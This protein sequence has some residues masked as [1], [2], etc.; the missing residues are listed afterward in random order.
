MSY[1]DSP[2]SL[3]SIADR[4]PR[5]SLCRYCFGNSSIIRTSLSLPYGIEFDTIR[6]YAENMDAAEILTAARRQAGLSL[7][8]LARRSGTSHSAL[9]AYESR[10]TVPGFD[11]LRRV[12]AAAGYGLDWQ[13]VADDRGAELAAVLEL[14]E[15]FPARHDIDPQYPVFGRIAAS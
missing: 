13:L 7:R 4:I 6:R 11:T 5:S 9:A 14:A 15:H 3:P 2:S 1:S 10:R 8:E 12:V